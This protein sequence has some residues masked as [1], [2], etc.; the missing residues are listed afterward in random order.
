MNGL[1]AEHTT[2]IGVVTLGAGKSSRMGR[3]KLLLPWGQTSVLGHLI[4]QWRG[5]GAKQIAVVYALGD[6]AMLGELDRLG[7]PAADRISNSAPDRGMF[8]SIQCAARWA[9]WQPALTHWAIVLGD[10]PLVRGETLRGLLEYS[11]TR[12]QMICQPVRGG[13]GRHPVVL[14][15][16][17]FAALAE[18]AAPTLKAFLQVNAQALAGFLADDPGLE[19]DIDRPEDYQRALEL[20][21]NEELN[22]GS[23]P[24]NNSRTKYESR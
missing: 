10:Q 18:T 1:A 17:A 4:E 12:P 11:A 22:P 5:I 6:Q 9:G 13:R 7:F 21:V 23:I 16:Q 15:R 14:P 19:V 24:A 2:A 8:S 20:A 3:P